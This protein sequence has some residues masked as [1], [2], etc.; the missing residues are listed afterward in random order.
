M[1]GLTKDELLAELSLGPATLNWGAILAFNRA[2]TNTVLLQEY[3]N[4]FSSSNYLQ[5]VQGYVPGSSTV[6]QY[7]TDYVMDYPRLSFEIADVQNE[8]PDARLTMKV[9]G[10]TQVTF[11]D[12]PGGR[13][14]TRVEVVDPLNGPELT[15]KVF[16]NNAPATIDSAGK[17][18]LDL[19]S[20]SN[21]SLS[22]SD[23]EEERQLG[24]AFFQTL[25]EA[26]PDEKRI[27]V[28]SEIIVNPE[29]LIKPQSIKL[30][31]QAAPGA[32][33]LAAENFGDGAVLVYVAMQGELIGDNPDDNFPYM[34]PNDADSSVTILLS[35]KTL[36]SM[37][38]NMPTSETTWESYQ[39]SVDAK[40]FYAMHPVNGKYHTE[41]DSSVELVDGVNTH[42][43]I[44]SDLYD[45]NKGDCY[46]KVSPGQMDMVW[47]YL[48]EEPLQQLVLSR[49]PVNGPPSSHPLVVKWEVEG[50]VRYSLNQQT[51]LIEAGDPNVRTLYRI[52][53][54]HWA[55]PITDANIVPV[56][57]RMLPH[58]THPD[59]VRSSM[60]RAFTDLMAKM[61]PINTFVLENLLFKEQDSVTLDDVHLP[62]DMVIFGRVGPT[63]T[64]FAI[65]PVQP[66]IGAGD[67]FQFNTKPPRTGL[68]WTA[69]N[70]LGDTGDAGSF[71]GEG[72][73][74]A[75]AGISGAFKRVKVTA[76]SGS[77]S[78]S[79]L[80]SIVVND[81][82]I[83]PVVQ[84]C[85]AT[86]S[87]TFSAGTKDSGVLEG[88]LKLP[89][90]GNLEKIA[91]GKWKYTAADLAEVG[92]PAFALDEILVTNCLTGKTKS[93]YIFA[94]LATFGLSVTKD[95]SVTLPAN[96]IKLKVMSST[97]LVPDENLVW[98]TLAGNGEVVNGVFTQPEILEHRFALLLAT[99]EPIPEWKVE[100]FIL[101]PLPLFEYPTDETMFTPGLHFKAV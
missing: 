19:S 13:E 93:A 80:V 69:E 54:L 17:V 22:Y 98:R 65:D 11:A 74:Q 31:T 45:L 46:I 42:C 56:S 49:A 36:M 61:P 94:A 18:M 20:S 33:V 3:I 24:G 64:K 88:D 55:T 66:I 34:I 71:S 48:S 85:G 6:G 97:A 10:G 86:H 9:I 40:G 7:I 47:R 52:A 99:F 76:S 51:Q 58:F 15:L 75:P 62:G 53:N 72:L 1:A 67:N 92:E 90:S 37:I 82:T 83:S 4:R 21:F 57:E 23:F 29:D 68:T 8:I 44:T 14:A 100:G 38:G 43:Y 87:R 5:P 2:D 50:S 26:L 60:L 16:L 79:A 32:K 81:I 28:I 77:H 78:S 96:Q 91:D 59:R 12:I 89:K 84:T 63:V 41:G 30:R 70:I 101:L 73:Y 27:M 35:N 39:L 95:A 25:F